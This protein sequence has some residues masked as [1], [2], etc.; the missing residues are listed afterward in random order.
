M[1]STHHHR[2][3]ASTKEAVMALVTSKLFSFNIWIPFTPI[4]SYIALR[5]MSFYFTIIWLLT[6]DLEKIFGQCPLTWWIFFCQISLKSLVSVQMYHIMWNQCLQTMDNSQTDETDGQQLA[7]WPAGWPENMTLSAYAFGRIK[8]SEIA[9]WQVRLKSP[10]INNQH[11]WT[12]YRKLS[13]SSSPWLVI[14]YRYLIYSH[15]IQKNTRT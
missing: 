13:T 10:S 14:N 7:S 2:I 3:C 1:A 5:A 4:M 12:K 9:H 11:H 8:G 15:S 6:S